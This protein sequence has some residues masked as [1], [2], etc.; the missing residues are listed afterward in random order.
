MSNIKEAAVRR[1]SLNYLSRINI[2]WKTGARNVM[3]CMKRD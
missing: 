3:F 1:V 2:K